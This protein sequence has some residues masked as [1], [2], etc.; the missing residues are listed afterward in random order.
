MSFAGL[1][2]RSRLVLLILWL[3]GSVALVATLVFAILFTTPYR[4]SWAWIS[5]IAMVALEDV[6]AG[7]A[8]P[9]WGWRLPR[10]TLVATAIVFRKHPDVVVLVALAA[11]PLASLVLRQAWFTLLGKSSSWILAAAAGWLS[12]RVVGFGDTSHFVLATAALLLIYAS[13]D[14]AL[15]HALEGRWPLL[16]TRAASRWVGTVGLAVIGALLAL[17]WRTPVVGPVM[18][19]LGEVC[20]LAMTGMVIGWALGGTARW[21]S[22]GMLSGRR[23]PLA[24]AAGLAL[25]AI[26]TRVPN[27]PSAIF[28]A[29]GLLGIGAWVLWRRVYYAAILVTGGLLNEVVRLV[30][31]GRMPVDVATLPPAIQ[32]DLTDLTRD[33]STYRLAGPGTH[34]SWLAD[35]F[36]IPVFPGIASIGDIL[37]AIGIIWMA[38][39]LTIAPVKATV[40]L[41]SLE[42]GA[43]EGAAA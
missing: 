21:P 39:A 19:R 20:V 10:L 32:S 13:L 6:V 26:S 8:Q 38:A 7:H 2:Q 40:V 11:A 3:S 29:G 31:G 37:I 25:L 16:W 4:T 17:G 41:P 9:V 30:N 27:V 5:F 1:T 18:L 43:G 12:L 23:L 35:R 33:S 15:Q 28:A 42:G 34:L 22:A 24:V 14:G 36:P